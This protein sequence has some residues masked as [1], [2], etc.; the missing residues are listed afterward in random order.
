LAV[1]DTQLN[2]D[3]YN[4]IR[5]LYTVTI[6]S[7][8]GLPQVTLV[9]E[10]DSLSAESFYWEYG[11]KMYDQPN[12]KGKFQIRNVATPGAGTKRILKDFPVEVLPLAQEPGP[13]YLLVW[14]GI[15]DMQ[16]YPAAVVEGNLA[17]YWKTARNAG[18]KVAA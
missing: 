14:A 8:A 12:W 2:L 1:F 17:S 7:G 13:K 4:Q 9:I 18:F 3:Q 11:L 5:K 16:A 15:N 6:G 10:G